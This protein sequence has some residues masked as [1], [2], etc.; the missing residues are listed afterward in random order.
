MYALFQGSTQAIIDTLFVIR[1]SKAH[2]LLVQ[3]CLIHIS[4]FDSRRFLV[5]VAS[6]EFPTAMV[7]L[8]LQVASGFLHPVSF[9]RVFLH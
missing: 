3:T 8:L 1:L 2:M 5:F 9:L 6:S 4:Q 7:A